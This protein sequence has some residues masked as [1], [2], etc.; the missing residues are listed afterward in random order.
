MGRKTHTYLRSPLWTLTEGQ[1]TDT[2]LIDL[3]RGEAN[4]VELNLVDL[5][6]S[7]DAYNALQACVRRLRPILSETSTRACARQTSSKFTL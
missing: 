3:A 4:L 6:L 1:D 7:L 5:Q 2:H